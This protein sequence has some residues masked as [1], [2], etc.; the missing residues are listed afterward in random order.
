MRSVIGLELINK[1]KK[2]KNKGFLLGTHQP[3][4]ILNHY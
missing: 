2:I 3:S 1:W 4:P